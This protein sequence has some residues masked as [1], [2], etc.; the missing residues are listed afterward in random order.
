[1]H[2]LD[3]GAVR[4]LHD[5]WYASSSTWF[6]LWV[7]SAR[8]LWPFTVFHDGPQPVLISTY[9]Q[10]GTVGCLQYVIAACLRMDF[11]RFARIICVHYTVDYLA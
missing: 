6:L 11:A 5:P 10:E 9:S 3:H 7:G 8:Y 2:F 4:K 1:M